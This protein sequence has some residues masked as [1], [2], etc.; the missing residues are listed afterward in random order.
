MK[1]HGIALSAL[2]SSTFSASDGWVESVTAVP[3]GLCILNPTRTDGATK[4][5]LEG[6]LKNSCEM[7]KPSIWCKNET[8][9][10][11]VKKV[12]KEDNQFEKLYQ[13]VHNGSKIGECEIF[14][15][16]IP[17]RKRFL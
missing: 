2:L 4:F 11:S 5:E 9:F 3:L 6:F 17:S 1:R 10:K 15:G 14:E 12:H 16:K 8:L 7:K 13:Y